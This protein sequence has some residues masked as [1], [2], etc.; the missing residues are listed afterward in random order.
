MAPVMKP[1]RAG[2]KDLS[3]WWAFWDGGGALGV[4]DG[5]EGIAD[6]Y[7]WRDGIGRLGETTESGVDSWLGV[8]VD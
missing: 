2:W 5:Y 8:V 6:W 4:A 7:C 1:V 3:A